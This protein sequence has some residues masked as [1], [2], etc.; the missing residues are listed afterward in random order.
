[1]KFLP[2]E[3]FVME[4]DLTPEQVR[5]ALDENI[6]EYSF[7]FSSD[8]MGQFGGYTLDGSFNMDLIGFRNVA[9][10]N[11]KGK[12]LKSVKGSVI[13]VKIRP[14]L[15]QLFLRGLLFSVLLLVALL[16]VLEMVNTQHFVKQGIAVY[17]FVIGLPIYW[18]WGFNVSSNQV[19]EKLAAIFDCTIIS[20]PQ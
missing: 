4:T 12:V 18:I 14:G 10:L 5:A 9:Q 7:D 8:C 6:I 13:N 16:L 20:N 3:K 11:V 15:I 1:M 2:F 19:K 17:I